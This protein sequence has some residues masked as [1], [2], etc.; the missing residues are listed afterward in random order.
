MQVS[1]ATY[2]LNGTPTITTGN[3]GKSY[4]RGFELDA[5]W[6]LPVE[7]LTVR[8]ALAYNQ[9]RY[10]V[11]SFGCYDGQSIAQGC[12]QVLNP[13]TGRYT[14]Q[15]LA[16]QHIVRSPDWGGNLGLSYDAT[17]GNYKLG[18]SADGNYT[19]WY[20]TN[21]LNAPAARQN[22]YWLWDASLR[23]GAANDK[24]E[25]A[26]IGRN[27]GNKAYVPRTAQVSGTGGLAGTATA[28]AQ[29]AIMGVAGRGR[30]I[31]VRLSLRPNLF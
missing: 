3:A 21:T 6:R 31:M 23:L 28:N 16:G 13:G 2:D 17:V 27:L 20:F 9:A 1:V 4:L 14:L 18:L 25:V 12:N 29:D 8:G 5:N 19:G 11:F 22:A 10:T 24:W 30:E 15:D 26:L 7:G